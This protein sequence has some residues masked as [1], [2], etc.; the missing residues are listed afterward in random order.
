MP[1]PDRMCTPSTSPFVTALPANSLPEQHF[2]GGADGADRGAA[3]PVAELAS[4]I[5]AVDSN[6]A[7]SG[8]A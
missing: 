7:V 2:T 8:N 4:W 3:G 5:R 1:A 6:I